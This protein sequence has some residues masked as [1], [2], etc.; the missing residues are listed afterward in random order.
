MFLFSTGYDPDF[1]KYEVGTI[2]FLRMI[3]DAY[4]T[5]VR[6]VDFGL[7]PAAYKER[8]GDEHWEE[9]HFYLFAPALR[10]LVPNGLLSVNRLVDN[11]ALWSW[12]KAHL[13]S[14]T[15]RRWKQRP[16]LSRRS[17]VG[18]PVE[19]LASTKQ[20]NGDDVND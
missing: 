1:R 19:S 7:G 9:K 6:P 4:G 3:A 17:V 15:K 2:L 18:T 20:V 8:F 13:V 10:G 11:Y 12:E 5:G 16:A 14:R